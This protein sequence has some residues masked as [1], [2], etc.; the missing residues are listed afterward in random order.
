MNTSYFNKYKGSN[1]IS[2][3]LKPPY[4]YLGKQYIQLAPPY[5][6]LIEYKRNYD[7]DFYIKNYYKE[8][9]D[10]LNPKIVYNDLGENA[11]L[12]C[13]EKP[14]E[15]CHRHIVSNWLNYELDINISELE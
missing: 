9:L 2:I 10:K 13:W 11:I 7:K 14:E 12:L 4:W 3:C 6:L 5:W 15:F 8:V 1:A